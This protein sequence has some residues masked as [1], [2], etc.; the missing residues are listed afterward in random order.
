MEHQVPAHAHQSAPEIVERHFAPCREK[1]PEFGLE[2]LPD[3]ALLRCSPPIPT[4]SAEQETPVGK[5]AEV[6][7]QG[8]IVS[9]QFLGKPA[10]AL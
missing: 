5:Q 7:Q 6:M 2:P 9:H 10:L 1:N 3:R 8:A 4:A